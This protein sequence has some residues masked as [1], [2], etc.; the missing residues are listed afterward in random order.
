MVKRS[1]IMITCWRGI[2]V[3][4]HNAKAYDNQLILSVGKLEPKRIFFIEQN[5]GKYTG[6]S[7]CRL[8]F[9]ESLQFLNASL[10]T[11]VLTLVSD[12]D[13]SIL[14]RFPSL[15]KHFSIPDHFNLLMRNS[16]YPYLY[17][18]SVA[19]LTETAIPD[20]TKLHNTLTDEYL[21]WTI[22]L[23]KQYGKPSIFKFRR[24]LRIS[25]LH[26]MCYYMQMNIL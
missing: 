9:L 4:M 5:K 7:I 25:M 26:Q 21:K 2:T 14:H 3:D 10:D 19:C 15:S 16:V 20:I 11:L 13:T 12:D 22:D 8:R 1:G 17:M 6:Y 18:H 23:L 24:L